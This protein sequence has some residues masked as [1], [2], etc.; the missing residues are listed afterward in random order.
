MSAPRVLFDYL[1]NPFD[2]FSLN[3]GTQCRAS[4]A[5]ISKVRGFDGF[6]CF[7]SGTQ[8]Q[9]GTNSIGAI[10]LKRRERLAEPSERFLS[11]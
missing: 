5:L 6:G 7:T 3:R 8:G 10:S 1:A 9:N 2:L 11:T 4:E